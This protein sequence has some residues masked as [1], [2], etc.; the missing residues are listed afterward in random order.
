MLDKISLRIYILV[1]Y[2]FTWLQSFAQYD[3]DEDVP[4]IS[5]A[6]DDMEDNGLMD[7]HRMPRITF[8]QIIMILLLIA[9]CYVFGKIWKG[10]TYLILILAAIFYYMLH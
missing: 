4:S 6:L 9:C 1:V 5:R 7:M 3:D 8:K 10:C 2:A